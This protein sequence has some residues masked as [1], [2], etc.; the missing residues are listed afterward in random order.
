MSIMKKLFNKQVIVSL[1]AIVIV[2]VMSLGYAAL[3]QQLKV[4]GN[5]RIDEYLDVDIVEGNNP[6]CAINITTLSG[7][8]IVY[9]AHTNKTVSIGIK[10]RMPHAGKNEKY[11]FQ[12]IVTF[13]N[14]G[15]VTATYKETTTTMSGYNF[16]GYSTGTTLGSMTLK[17]GETTKAVIWFDSDTATIGYITASFNWAKST[18]S[19]LPM[20]GPSISMPGEME[21]P[22]ETVY[23]QF[24]AGDYVML[25]GGSRWLVTKDTGPTEEYV[26][27]LYDYNDTT[28]N[29]PTMA[30]DTG[31]SSEYNTNASSNI[32]YYLDK[33]LLPEIRK[34]IV[35][36]AGSVSG[37]SIRLPSHEEFNN[38]DKILYDNWIKSDV[39]PPTLITNYNAWLSDKVSDNE[40]K[41]SSNKEKYFYNDGTATFTSD[42]CLVTQ[43]LKKAIPV[44]RT[45][46]NNV[47]KYNLK[48]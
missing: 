34:S 15:N 7:Y 23:P 37:L 20:P 12:C 10:R 1:V 21:I 5:V 33:T 31:G 36:S 4:N 41:C 2:F 27:L 24:N 38:I 25:K 18:S 48:S 3:Q 43:S 22:M 29:I 46:K 26:D 28:F 42:T 13:K 39:K 32:G 40:V 9:S 14:I 19:D 16:K 47:S 11:T 17:P 44:I 8:G 35:D 45:S 6:L 30:F